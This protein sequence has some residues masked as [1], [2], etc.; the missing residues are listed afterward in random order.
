MSLQPA[1]HPKSPKKVAA[2]I[3]GYTYGTGGAARSPVSPADLELLKKT[4][5][6]TPDDEK[7]LR[8]AGEVLADQ[9]EN[10]VKAWRAVIAANPHLAKYSLDSEGRPIAH[11]SAASGLRFRQWILDTCFRPYDQ[12]WLNYQQEIALRHTSV[13]KNKT[14][15]V[16]SAVSI[17]LRYVIAFTAVINDGI[18]P[19][20][21]A[22]GH[23]PQD[24][25]RMHRAWCKSVQLQIALWS[26]PYT[27]S[28]VAPDEW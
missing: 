4:V 14:D 15:H 24:V 21:S 13:K 11:Y 18:K 8:L 2:D 9:T 19:F 26:E 7:Y 23:S 3:P 27:N 22:R 12:D 5:D 28:D 1:R 20:L 6:F 16:E 17:P 25:E 10:V